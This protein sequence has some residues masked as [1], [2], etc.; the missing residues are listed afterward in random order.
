MLRPPE[1]LWTATAD[2]LA[3]R[4][5]QNAAA[6]GASTASS[7]CA[8]ARQDPELLR[9]LEGS[10]APADSPVRCGFYAGKRLAKGSKSECTGS[11]MGQCGPSVALLG[12]A[13]GRA[14]VVV[15]CQGHSLWSQATG[16][17]E[18]RRHESLR[19][20]TMPPMCPQCS[21]IAVGHDRFACYCPCACPTRLSNASH[22]LRCSANACQQV[23][24][25]RGVSIP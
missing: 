9:C 25:H 6:A 10:G 23:A 13:S 8:P 22:D 17:Q 5:V 24:S 2:S 11:C 20:A 15:A 7:A 19:I 12:A 18:V 3:R 16:A 4:A 21:A 1:L 14:Y